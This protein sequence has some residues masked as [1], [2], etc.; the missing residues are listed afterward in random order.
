MQCTHR[1]CD[2]VHLWQDKHHYGKQCPA[3]GDGSDHL[4]ETSEVEWPTGEE[5][6]TD[7]K[8]EPNGDLQMWKSYQYYLQK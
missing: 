3:E 4:A 7:K 8:P 2:W 6:V 1:S 5:L